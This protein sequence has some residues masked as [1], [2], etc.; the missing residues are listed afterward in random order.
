LLGMLSLHHRDLELMALLGR[1][2]GYSLP[3]FVE[4][5]CK[6]SQPGQH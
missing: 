2:V 6:E 4:N 1:V 3:P 5:K